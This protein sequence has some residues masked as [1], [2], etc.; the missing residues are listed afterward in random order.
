MFALRRRMVRLLT[1]TI[2]PLLVGLVVLAP[3]V[4]PWLFGPDW[5]PA[6][7]PTQLLA[8]AGGNS[9]SA[10]GDRHPHRSALLSQCAP[11]LAV[12]GRRVER[13]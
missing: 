6:V 10:V 7:L 13:S 8:G 9:R 2:F 3:V 11:E 1:M 5:V 12:L 4:V